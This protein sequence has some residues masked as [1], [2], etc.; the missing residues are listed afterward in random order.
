MDY[1]VEIGTSPAGVEWNV[2]VSE[3]DDPTFTAAKIAG[4]KAALDN[5][6]IAHDLRLVSVR[7]LTP[8]QLDWVTDEFPEDSIRENGKTIAI[9]NHGD[10]VD[11]ADALLERAEEEDHSEVVAQNNFVD[12]TD[13]QI[14]FGA[15][16][17]EMSLRIT[18]DK[19]RDTLKTTA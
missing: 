7:G 1:R 13:A 9:G 3:G 4:Q 18:V 17:R 19:I 10:W 5:L 11:V 8:A 14:A 16:G 2:Y 12:L 15:K 6:W